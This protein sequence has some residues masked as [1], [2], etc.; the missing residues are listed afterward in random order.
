M[1]DPETPAE[2]QDAVNAAE[3]CLLIDSA[4]QYGLITG[5]PGVDVDR[6]VQIVDRGRAQQIVPQRDGVEDQI[7]ALISEGR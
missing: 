3:A 4:R 5:G 2:W 7:Q 6:C 1:R